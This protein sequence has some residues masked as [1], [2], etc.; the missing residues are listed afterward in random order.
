MVDLSQAGGVDGLLY[1]H[2]M[3]AASMRLQCVHITEVPTQVTIIQ[4]LAWLR[5]SNE[6]VNKL[7][8]TSARATNEPW[9]RTILHKH[10]V[11]D[12]TEAEVHDLVPGSVLKPVVVDTLQ[13]SASLSLLSSAQCTLQHACQHTRGDAD[14]LSKP[15]SLHQY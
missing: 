8:A 11:L 2:I 4:G 3:Y 6:L 14:G 1:W 10:Q 12:S 5:I 15:R 9:S 13:M 7:Q